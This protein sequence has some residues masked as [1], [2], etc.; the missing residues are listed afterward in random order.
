MFRK[1]SLVVLSTGLVVS[2]GKGNGYVGVDLSIAGKKY[3]R[4]ISFSQGWSYPPTDNNGLGYPTPFKEYEFREG[5]GLG[6]FLVAG[7]FEHVFSPP[8]TKSKYRVNL[9][10]AK[11]IVAPID[12]D[13][14]EKATQKIMPLYR[15]SIFRTAT[16]I[17]PDD[18]AEFQGKIFPRTGPLWSTPGDGSTRLSPDQQWLV[19]QSRTRP[20]R[21]RVYFDVFNVGTGSKLVTLEGPL[22][23]VWPDELIYR[24]GWLAGRY[25]VIPT[26]DNF[27]GSVICDFGR[28]TK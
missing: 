28:G 17:A 20:G 3:C 9:S 2:C 25:F 13:T 5:N 14:W 16:T 10:S 11:P 7:S 6:D 27:E 15:K 23:A 8:Y 22:N 26:G 1:L 21:G 24:T 12:D 19:L 18:R 4:E